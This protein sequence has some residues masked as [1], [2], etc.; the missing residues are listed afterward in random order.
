MDDKATAHGCFP[1]AV[2][3]EAEGDGWV[4]NVGNNFTGR[5]AW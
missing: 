5:N 2:D 1:F 3:S 4:T